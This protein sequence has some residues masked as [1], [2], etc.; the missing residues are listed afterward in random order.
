MKLLPLLISGLLLQLLQ[1]QSSS[2]QSINK[3]NLISEFKIYLAHFDN[4]RWKDHLNMM[5][6]EYIEYQ[7]KESQLE[8][9]SERPFSSLSKDKVVDI[10]IL[11]RR[12]GKLHG[13]FIHEGITYVFIDHQWDALYQFHDTDDLNWSYGF[14]IILSSLITEYESDEV[15]DNRENKTVKLTTTSTVK[16][17]LAVKKDGQ[18]Q[19]KFMEYDPEGGFL[20]VFVFSDDIAE[21]LEENYSA[22]N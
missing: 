6:P 13:E 17:V 22:E 16:S 3:D 8:L 15:I 11:N 12:I 7:G 21:L 2:A 19:W 18:E 4:S 10:D 9:L 14:D 20:Y 5:V 1:V